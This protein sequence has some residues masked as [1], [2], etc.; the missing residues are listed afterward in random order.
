MVELFQ[1]WAL[2]EVL[3]FICLPLTLTIFK[4]LPDRGWAFS[5]I[6]GMALLAFCVWLPLMTLQ[7]LPFSRLFILGILLLILALNVL[8]FPRVWK[9]LVELARAHL[10]YLITC[11]L[12]Y[13]GMIFL[14]GWVRSYNPNIQSFEM[15]MDEGFLASIMRAQHFPPPD[16]WLSGYPINYY[17]YAHYT[18]A[19]LAKLIGQPASIA[20]NTGIC[21]F[22]GLTGVN[23]FGITCNI[24]AL[25]RRARLQRQRGESGEIS[26]ASKRARPRRQRPAAQSSLLTVAMPFGVVS[27]LMCVVLGNLASTQS[28]W[29]AHDSGLPYFYWFNVSR[30]VNNTINEFPAFSFL[31]SCFHAHVLTLAFTILAIALIFNLF[32]ERGGE[33]EDGDAQGLRIFGRGWRLPLNLGFMAVVIG[34]LFAMNGWDF[35]TY[36][37]TAIVCIALQ[38]WMA[39]HSRFSFELALDVFTV[40]AS[41]TAL[42]FFL[43]AP[44]YLNFISP[45]QGIGIV[46]AANRS[47]VSSEMLIYGTFM[48]LFVTLLFVNFLRERPM[49]GRLAFANQRPDNPGQ[50][51]I[52]PLLASLSRPSN[53]TSGAHEVQSGRLLSGTGITGHA[54]SGGDLPPAGEQPSAV[55]TPQQ[56]ATIAQSLPREQGDEFEEPAGKPVQAGEPLSPLPPLPSPAPA[57]PARPPWL[58]FRFVSQVLIVVAALLIYV[59]VKNSLWLVI[60]FVITA[61]GAALVLYH[62]QDR[63]RAFTLLL[64]TVAFGLVAMTEVVYLKDVFASTFPRM[65]TVFKFYFQAWALLAITSGAGLYF[66]VESFRPN[67]KMDGLQLLIRRSGQAIWTVMCL[68]LLL[69]GAIYPIYGSY[70]RTNEFAQR[71]NSLDGMAYL[72]Q[73]SPG[74]Y[75]AIQWLNHNVQGSPVVAEAFGPEGGDY[76]DYGRVSAFTG[77]PTI[78]GWAGHEYQWR[79]NW[80][81]DSTNAADFYN[82]GTDVNLIYTSKDPKIVLAILQRYQVRY[83]YV[84]NLEIAT[85]TGSDLTRFRNFLPVV[86]SRDGVT[87]YQ[88]PIQGS[89]ATS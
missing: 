59:L 69:A 26:R 71:T 78:I 14:L 8:A 49:P 54:A 1:M 46:D 48:F 23:I 30:V 2:V 10:T 29:Q 62:V 12:L 32:L 17:Y 75:E 64:G 58:T 24:V 89:Q 52:R 15:F 7:F 3:G 42:S 37:G 88:V 43:Y 68:L 87:I 85:Y 51:P 82:R 36:L 66:I 40:S 83:L 84:G 28:W 19:V 53:G 72:Q 9:T 4:N 50:L 44:F 45:S 27:V 81:N 38:Q 55:Q 16:M 18:I 41:L 63:P 22:F 57:R 67:M 76:S 25:A 80:L 31:L 61:L 35:P 33:G 47:S 77:L 86:Y 39:H 60:A 34:G 6:V 74:D 13:L 56:T 21:T 11:E 70:Q 79:V 20:F 5:K 65:N 73:Y